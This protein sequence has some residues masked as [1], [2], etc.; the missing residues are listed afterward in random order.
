LHHATLRLVACVEQMHAL[1]DS[2]PLTGLSGKRCFWPDTPAAVG[3]K[4]GH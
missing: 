3:G 4:V 2:V 1:T